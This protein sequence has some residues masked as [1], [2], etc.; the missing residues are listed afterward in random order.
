MSCIPDTPR[1]RLL[2]HIVGWDAAASADST[3]GLT[4]FDSNLGVRL[5]GGPDGVAPS[6]VDP[7]IAPPR[8]SPGC[9]PCDYYL[10]TGP[11]KGGEIKRLDGCSNIWRPAWKNGCLPLRFDRPLA[12]AVDRH[13]IAIADAGTQRVWILLL[14]GVQVQGEINAT[15]PHDLSFGPN[16][17]LVVA[18]HGGTRLQVFSRNGRALGNWPAA[19]PP[20]IITRIAH[21]PKGRLWLVV[22][23]GAPR[24]RL[25]AQT[26]R[27]RPEFSEQ[28]LADLADAFAPT[29]VL[30]S[31]DNG[32]CL[33]RGNDSGEI[34][35]ICYNYYG[36]E[37]GAECI[38]GTN[39][40]TYAPQGQ[41]LT[42]AIDSGLARCIWHRIDI[43]ADIP[44][45]TSVSI[46]VTTS[47]TAHPAAQGHNG[48]DWSGFPA[49]LPHPDDWQSIRPDQTDALIQ[50]PAGRYLFVRLRL[51]GDTTATPLVRRVHIDFPR[52]TSANLLPAV[53]RENPAS[54]DFTERF[55][56][57]F[58]ATLDS[59]DATIARFPAMLNSDGVNGD[60]LPWIAKFLAI[61]LDENWDTDTRR[62]MLG[63]APDLFRRRGTREGLSRT[64]QLAYGLD[65]QPVIT[66]HGLERAWGAVAA[67]NG[68][69]PSAA[70]LGQ[71]RLFGRSRARLRL[72]SSQIGATPV[73]SLGDPAADPH[74]VGAF[75]FSVGL[76]ATAVSDTR[77]LVRLIDGQKPAHTIAHVRQ[78]AGTGFVL[79]T[80]LRVGIDTAI[81][82]PAPKPLGDADFRLSRGAILGGQPL[83]GPVL[84]A[85]TL[86]D[87][88]DLPS[89]LI[90]TE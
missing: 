8:L 15:D 43:D 53:Y 55:L 31:D 28:T 9:H 16:G 40:S 18:T 23:S 34:G 67:S 68:Q 22:E 75:R 33:A 58:D 39:P 61:T 77:S 44:A 10:A 35:E 12:V 3:K 19:V 29:G 82:L 17:E 52:S 87:P 62:R 89:P 36:R 73:L 51:M 69:T 26:S 49:G 83:P 81:A 14:H 25:F 57:L 70:R 90:C 1:F 80:G 47:E 64:I 4:G 20:A 86:T 6:A 42:R 72:G 76:P 30:R 88:T 56:S 13:R 38:G 7:F 78:G 45:G 59:I 79:G 21:D 74:E 66:E 32:F 85:A 71:T 60:V 65:Q 48:P 27:A 11:G 54:T 46:A 2:D 41:L 24:F 37:I 50:Q 84:G 63:A 5:T